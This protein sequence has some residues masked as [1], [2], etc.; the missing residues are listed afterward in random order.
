MAFCPFIP[1]NYVCC[2]QA[3]I[4]GWE[5][6]LQGGESEVSNLGNGSGFSVREVI[7]TSKKVTGKEIKIEERD[8]R[9]GDPPILV[10]SSDK[11]RQKLG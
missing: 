7:G 5:Y 6:L 3:H 1:S 11:A 9:A 2:R 8:R 10:G 4:L